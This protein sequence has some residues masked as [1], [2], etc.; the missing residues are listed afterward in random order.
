MTGSGEDGNGIVGDKRS[1][2]G[3]R[4]RRLGEWNGATGFGKIRG[5]VPIGFIE[6]KL[7]SIGDCNMAENVLVEI[8]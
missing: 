8:L 6:V 1:G 3:D 4:R 5:G 2:A 7:V